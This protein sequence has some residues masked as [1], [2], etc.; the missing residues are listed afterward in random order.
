M[1][2]S[3]PDIYIYICIYI[4]IY[5]YIYIHIYYPL[6]DSVGYLMPSFPTKSQLEE[7]G[8]VYDFRSVHFRHGPAAC[9][10]G[11]HRADLP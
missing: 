11:H 10:P 4:I 2:E 5:T 6:R 8:S 1:R 7:V 3:G 9:Q